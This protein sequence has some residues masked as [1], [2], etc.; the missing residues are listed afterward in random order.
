MISLVIPQNG[1]N[2]GKPIK[3]KKHNA[4][5]Y[6]YTHWM[7]PLV[8][9]TYFCGHLLDFN[10]IILSYSGDIQWEYQNNPYKLKGKA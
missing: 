10:K 3:V 5:S 7:Y 8:P 1:D 9:L 2:R 6:M 4:K